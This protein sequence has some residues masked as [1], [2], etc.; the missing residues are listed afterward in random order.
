MSQ[1]HTSLNSIASTTRKKLSS[2]P[3]SSSPPRPPS[4]ESTWQYWEGL[5]PSSSKL[6]NTSASHQWNLFK[7]LRKD[8][9]HYFG[10]LHGEI[11]T[12]RNQVK[13]VDSRLDS[14]TKQ[15]EASIESR[16]TTVC[17]EIQGCVKRDI[18]QVNERIDYFEGHCENWFNKIV[19]HIDEIPKGDDGV[20]LEHSSCNKPPTPP[21]SPRVPQ[22]IPTHND[23][24]KSKPHKLR[25]IPIRCAIGTPPSL[26]NPNYIR[27]ILVKGGVSSIARNYIP[28]G[29][30]LLVAKSDAALKVTLPVY[31]PNAAFLSRDKRKG[32]ARTL[33]VWIEFQIIED[34][35]SV[36]SIG[37]D[38]I[39]ANGLNLDIDR[40][41]SIVEIRNVANSIKPFRI[42]IV[43]VETRTQTP[44]QTPAHQDP[45]PQ[46]REVSTESPASQRLLNTNRSPERH[47][48]NRNLTNP[49]SN[50][51]SFNSC[52]SYRQRQASTHYNP[53]PNVQH[54]LDHPHSSELESP[55]VSDKHEVFDMQQRLDQIMNEWK[56]IRRT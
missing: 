24:G 11:D 42:P 1:G 12:L 8:L 27:G 17:S 6:S 10:Y 20:L 44:T 49:S 54:K 43:N 15:I 9:S 53:P 47:S 37:Q 50:E 36:F 34:C 3:K 21:E 25:R 5:N 31:F 33:K 16:Y 22:I 39:K 14:C 32:N 45:Q 2:A 35:N 41:K 38:S 26:D 56:D 40:W 28:K 18:K 7:Q 4:Y 55:Y 51:T 23:M 52:N 48:T 46:C 30:K 13:R 29:F 19:S